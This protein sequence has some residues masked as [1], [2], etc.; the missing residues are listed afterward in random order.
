METRPEKR[1]RPRMEALADL[2]FG[3]SLS[4]GSIALIASAPASASQIDSHILAFIFAFLMLI[5]AWMI[6]T[7]QM[8]VLPADTR[9][10]RFLNVVLLLLVAL[11]PYLL[12]TVALTNASL[13]GAQASSLKD[14]ASTLF[15]LDLTG[16]LAILALFAHVISLEE[17]KLV[18][19]EVARSFR[20]GR[21][22]MV[23]LAFLMLLSILPVFWQ[24]TLFGTPL[25][26]YVWYA[27]LAAYWLG[28]AFRPE[29]AAD[30]APDA[31]SS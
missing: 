21:N 25:R 9:L 4:I 22:T 2:I 18:S 14:Y 27:P 26:L 13:T 5:T 29:R 10:A 12:N 8:S 30:V 15:A 6:Y 3:L 19:P 16:V 1:P 7:S 20:R 31:T 28:E 23:F 11:V 17:K 24:L